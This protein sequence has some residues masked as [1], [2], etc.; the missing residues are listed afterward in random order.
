MNLSVQ[1]LIVKFCYR[2]IQV[3]VIINIIDV[4]FDFRFGF[5]F[6]TTNQNAKNYCHEDCFFQMFCDGLGFD[7]RSNVPRLAIVIGTVGLAANA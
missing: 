1:V 4:I 5:I 2:L 3:S 6:R 7:S